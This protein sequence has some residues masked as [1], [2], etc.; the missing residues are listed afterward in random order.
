MMTRK[1]VNYIYSLHC[2]YTVFYVNLKKKKTMSSHD[3]DPNCQPSTHA[4]NSICAENA[5]RPIRMHRFIALYKFK[6]IH[7]KSKNVIY[8]YS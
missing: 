8:I 5:N 6:Y 1:H 7:R 4:E 3:Q 2:L